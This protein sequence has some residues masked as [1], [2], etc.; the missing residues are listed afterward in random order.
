L[1]ADF[2]VLTKADAD[3]VAAF[4]IR[5]AGGDMRAYFSAHRKGRRW[6]LWQICAFLRRHVPQALRLVHCCN[7]ANE[8]PN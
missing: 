4:S 3:K 2:E 6:S 5:R 8:L 1:N 7:A